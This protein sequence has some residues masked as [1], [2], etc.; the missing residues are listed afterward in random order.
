MRR[1]SEKALWSSMKTWSTSG[2]P[3]SRSPLRNFAPSWRL[4]RLSH[5]PT[6]DTSRN[7]GRL[8]HHNLFWASRGKCSEGLI[9][10]YLHSNRLTIIN[11]PRSCAASVEKKSRSMLYCCT[12]QCKK[13]GSDWFWP[14]SPRYNCWKNFIARTS[15]IMLTQQHCPSSN[16]VTVTRK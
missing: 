13:G 16:S 7:S 1:T 11:H 6:H 3:S 8:W 4:C 2:R 5:N 15:W 10:G 12:W 14:R 9:P